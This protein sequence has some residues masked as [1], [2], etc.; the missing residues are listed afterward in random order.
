MCGIAGIMGTCPN[1]K[2]SVE[3]MLRVMYHR[4]PDGCKIHEEKEIT[5]GHV[6]LS[7]V[8]VASGSQPV[9]NEDKS[10]I[11][12]VNGEIY[13]YKELRDVLQR[14]GHTFNSQSDSEV[15]PHLYEVY[16]EKLFTML[17]GQFAIAIWDSKRKELILARDKL[18]EK[19][20]FYTKR[21]GV[22]YFASD[23]NAV[24]NIG[25][26]QINVNCLKDICSTWGPLGNHTIYQDVFSVKEGEIL[27][28]AND[29]KVE[30]PYF[31]INFQHNKLNG[32]KEKELE[33]RLEM[34]LIES[35]QK[36]IPSEVRS[37][38][39]LSGGLDSS[40]LVAIASKVCQD[41]VNTFSLSFTDA[42]FDESEYQRLIAKKFSKNHIE[43]KIKSLQLK[44]SFVEILHHIGMPVVRGGAFP[45]YFLAQK[46]AEEGYKVVLSGEGADELFGG[47]DVFKESLIRKF[48]ERDP[49]SSKRPLLYRKINPF[50]AGYSN[51]KSSAL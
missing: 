3:E 2:E 38:F 32:M 37:A 49:D 20:L 50:V 4:G 13:N 7:I 48:C 42:Q 12:V 18:G 27:I 15:I 36:R 51:N 19:P 31:Q 35:V 40:L 39:Y 9:F 34:L 45:M 25:K 44:Q 41:K 43:V 1:R 47:Y 11:S 16:R 21:E 30:F 6:R 17:D 28:L 29:K 46:V 24:S 10:I 14:K 26:R 23:I 5:M 8:D 22:Y 33:K